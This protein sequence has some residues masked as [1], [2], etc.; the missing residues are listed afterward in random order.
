S[1]QRIDPI[2]FEGQA[3]AHVHS[4]VGASGYSTKATVDDLSKS[5]CVSGTVTGDHTLYWAP[6]LYHYNEVD[7][8]FTQFPLESAV[9]YYLSFRD[10]ENGKPGNDIKPFPRG[11]RVTAGDAK[12]FKPFE[13]PIVGR[14]FGFKCIPKNQE[15]SKESTRE[16]PQVD[17]CEKL[18][19]E[20]TFP[21]CSK[22]LSIL[23]G[24]EDH[25]T[26]LVYPEA[27]GALSSGK[28]PASHPIR[29]PTVFHE[30]VYDVSKVSNVGG[31]R[32]VLSNG[33][34]VGYSL[35]ADMILN[36]DEELLAKAINDPSLG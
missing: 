10:M 21:S 9:T 14:G 32:W 36:W 16:I 12:N 11:M 22:D 34:T 7:K 4:F 13:N 29:L 8:T 20:I 1:T 35:H 17:N 3:A 19:L 26:H 33:D 24:K 6:T 15:P 30:W 28:C 31:G 5:E 23:G 2:V 25:A 27:V 18:R